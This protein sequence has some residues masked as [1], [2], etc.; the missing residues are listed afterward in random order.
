MR[1]DS[2]LN[3]ANCVCFCGTGL[4]IEPSS[5]HW[6]TKAEAL[7]WGERERSSKQEQRVGL[8]VNNDAHGGGE[9]SCN[10]RSGILP[11][12]AVAML[13]GHSGRSFPETNATTVNS[14]QTAAWYAISERESLCFEA[15]VTEPSNSFPT[16]IAVCT[17]RS[18]LILLFSAP[19]H[20]R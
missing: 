8:S 2:Y 6:E 11:V 16:S 3:K 14:T 10:G 12:A 15:L 19:W 20:E 5:K 9:S 18:F 4:L 7:G 13:S 17:A 1:E